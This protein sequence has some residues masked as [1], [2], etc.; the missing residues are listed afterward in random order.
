M[1]EQYRPEDLEGKVQQHWDTK[2][3]FQVTE[4]ASK[5]KFYCLS[6]FPYP[7]GRLH[8]G[9]V[10][11]YTIGDVISRYQRM[12]GKN[13][14]QPIGWDAFGLPAENAA[15]KNKTAP[16]PWTYDNIE[17]M[18]NQLKMLGFGYDW[19][20]EIA[21]CKPEYYRWEQWFFTK[22]YEKGL[23]YKK[24]SSVNWCPNDQTVLANEQVIEGCC[25]RC[26]TKVEQKEIPQWFIKI[27]D[28]ADQLLSDL[29]GLN[30]WPD[31]VKTMQ[32]NWIGRSE[33]VDI[34]FDIDGM[35]DSLTVYTTRPDTFMGVTYVGI[36]AGHPLAQK[37]A[38]NN[39]E[40]AAFI[41]EC[42][43]TKVA[44][45]ELATMEKKGVATGLYAIHPLNGRKV[46]VWVA[47]FVLMGYG[48]GAVMA[49]P[50][51][52]QRDYEFA[53]KYSLPIDAVIKPA[54][55][56][57]LDI[58]AQAYTEK[59]I[60]FNSGEFDG[61]DFDGAFNA[62][63]D[64]LN[65]IGKGERRVNFRLR[66]WGVSRQRYWG[67]PIPMITLE[68][69]T[70]I[71]TPEDMLPVVLPEDVTMDGV[72]SPIKAD[73]E[74]A[75]VTVN[76]QPALRETDTFDT[77]MESS[78]YYSRYTCPDYNDGMLNPAA[79]NYW[80]PVDQYIGGIEHATMHLLYFR[81][82]HKLLRDAGLVNS[83]EPAK[84]LLCQGMVLADAFYYT[85]SNG[86]RIWVSPTDA[87]ITERDDK[88]RI[89][90]AQDQDGHELVYAGMSKMSKS[91]NNGID[92]Q[93][94]VEKYGADTVRLF[95]MFASPAEM[96][97]EWQ[98]SGVEGANRFLKRLWRLAFEHLA[99][100]P[101]SALDVAALNADQKA[102]RRDLHKTIAKVSDD[103]G[104]RQT[105]NTAIA[106]VMELMNKLTRMPQ[107]TEQDRA[108]LQEALMA[109]VRMLYPITPHIC[110]ALWQELGG[111]GD[112]DVAPWP[113]ADEA[114]MVEDSKLVV[115]QVNG[116][117]RGKVTV[118]ADAT[119]EQV[120]EV[121]FADAN[122]AKHME[123]VSI[124]KVIYVPGKLL[125]VVVG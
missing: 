61:L 30:E 97:L 44:E 70:V 33:G 11:N 89:L 36:A 74:W 14:L 79:A 120:K 84:R 96:T 99:Q 109:V 41:N 88:G 114:A 27:T 71:P 83:D 35:D 113:V 117:L 52:D 43:N 90:K 20:R 77:F 100:G 119:E 110:F 32:R 46:P 107:E 108:L 93:E 65:S 80:L 48:T 21:T 37:A 62:V 51:H 101:V 15:I 92:P 94:M 56:S 6:M 12:Q 91:K 69:G 73:P 86:E 5:E 22:L 98:E 58:S 124:R 42:R 102:L 105:F 63:A 125:N 23:V 26:D 118:A 76:G 9:H 121:A 31:M 123:G 57:E 13:V 25:W 3:T 60:L 67:A 116:K 16:A 112:I 75:K 87:I 38:E 49:V 106:A 28:Y 81:F 115:V 50:A 7:S 24:T 82:F 78:W 34:T 4:D 85:G 68:D 29:D 95:M 18:K 8:M 40:L 39:P 45:A 55:G 111:E 64:K 2:K 104:R 53:T 103:I 17:Y 59:G 122:I 10:R 19:K 1:Q 47:N 54:D 72:Q 66:D